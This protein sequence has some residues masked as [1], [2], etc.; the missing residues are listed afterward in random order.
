MFPLLATLILSAGPEPGGAAKDL[1]IKHADGVSAVAFSPD[2]KRLLT[3]TV[4]GAVTL[5]DAASGREVATFPARMSAIRSLTWSSDGK[6]FASGG[7]DGR[8][9]LWDVAKKAAHA[10]MRCES[11]PVHSLAFTKDGDSLLAPDGPTLLWL[12]VKKGLKVTRTVKAGDMKESLHGIALSPDGK[13]VL[14]GGQVVLNEGSAHT[15][16]RSVDV[17]RGT[18]TKITWGNPMGADQ[19]SVWSLHRAFVVHAPDGK[20]WA[21]ITEHKAILFTGGKLGKSVHGPAV[22]GLAYTPDGKTLVT[23]DRTGNVL[24]TDV[25]TAKKAEQIKGLGT[26]TGLA[27]SP[28]G[29]RFAVA[30]ADG[31]VLIRNVPAMKKAE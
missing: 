23:A 19:R 25:A 29:K 5:W 8:V 26:L 15:V 6:A 11:G 17:A 28:D 16:I 24:L 12:D 2:G 30:R 21:A 27:L 4:K 10:D 31:K 14:L 22:V 18:V 7:D 3:G 9:Y 13:S 20:G 1:E